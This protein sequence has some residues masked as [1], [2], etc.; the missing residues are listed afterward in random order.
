VKFSLG[1]TYISFY[2]PVEEASYGVFRE[3][4]NEGD[5]GLNRKN[6]N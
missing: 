6:V 3:E 2:T 4:A 5:K 1:K